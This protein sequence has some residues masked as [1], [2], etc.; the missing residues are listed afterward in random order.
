[1]V[2]TDVDRATFLSQFVGVLAGRTA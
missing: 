2:V 1:V